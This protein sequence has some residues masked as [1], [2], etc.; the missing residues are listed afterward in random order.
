VARDTG[1]GEQRQPHVEQDVGR[2]AR[3]AEAAHDVE[4]EAGDR[5]RGERGHDAHESSGVAAEQCTVDQQSREVRQRERQ[6]GAD[7]RQHQHQGETAPVWGYVPDEAAEVSVQGQKEI[8][9]YC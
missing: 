3:V 1:G 7:E 5:E 9:G 2:D 4:G 8:A 6:P